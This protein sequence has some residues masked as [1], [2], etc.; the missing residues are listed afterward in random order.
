M[1]KGKQ[2][3]LELDVYKG[4]A[5]LLV[6]L[7]HSICSF[8]VELSIFFGIKSFIG[9]FFMQ[10]F[11]LV[12]GLLYKENHSWR[13]FLQK[14]AKR[15]FVPWV[16]F[17]ILSITLRILASSFSRSHVEG[18]FQEL[19]SA[20]ITGKFFWFLYVLLII[21]IITKLLRYRYLLC[22]LGGAFIV[23]YVLG[24][25]PSLRY[26]NMNKVIM[27][28]PWFVAGILI[29]KYYPI[30]SSFFNDKLNMFVIISI[31]LFIFMF[32]SMN[33]WIEIR[34]ARLLSS[35]VLCWAIWI[36]SKWSLYA[37]N[38]EMILLTHFGRYSLQY[39]L[40][41]ILILLPCFYLGA[42]FYTYSQF[43]SLIVIF[44]SALTMSWLMLKIESM[45]SLS[46]SLC[47]L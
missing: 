27:Y 14:K 2:R 20:I 8:P 45:H 37:A 12:S 47:G 39:Y 44:L 26:L 7:F 24:I 31:I 17:V 25:A 33:N 19:I 1:D 6:I 38:G 15:L 46:R 40:N 35:V 23:I 5:I 32:L 18:F 13:T 11:F 29:K 43:I 10:M 4:I 41:H 22:I 3:Y 21:M 16:V 42:V 28:F 30:I 9:V 36:F 34:F